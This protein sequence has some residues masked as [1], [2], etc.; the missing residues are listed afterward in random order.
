MIFQLIRKD[1]LLIRKYVIFMIFFRRLHHRYYCGIW[2][3]RPGFL[4]FTV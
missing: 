2:M 4:I 3:W 1:L